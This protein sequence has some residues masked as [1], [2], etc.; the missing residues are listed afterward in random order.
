MDGVHPKVHEFLPQNT[1]LSPSLPSL[2]GTHF[3]IYSQSQARLCWFGIYFSPR[4]WVC[5]N[6]R[7]LSPRYRD[8]AV[9]KFSPAEIFSARGHGVSLF[10]FGGAYWPLATARIIYER[11]GKPVVHDCA[12][13]QRLS[14][15][16]VPSPHAP[17]C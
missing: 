16:R 9:P 12:S 2:W 3:V 13:V 14:L 1:H 15:P 17:G 11:D 7:Q 10:A 5:R 8:L 4:I 6:F